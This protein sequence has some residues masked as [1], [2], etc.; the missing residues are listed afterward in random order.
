L[1]PVAAWQAATNGSSASTSKI[2]SVSSRLEPERR[3]PEHR[4][5]RI[6]RDRDHELRVAAR[7]R[8]TGR[9]DDEER[10]PFEPPLEVREPAE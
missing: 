3:G 5:R 6:A 2:F 9:D 8:R 10:Q 4:A 1:P 7:R